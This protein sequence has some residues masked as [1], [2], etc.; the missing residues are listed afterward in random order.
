MILQKKTL[1][2]VDT[3]ATNTNKNLKQGSYGKIM[4]HKHSKLTQLMHFDEIFAAVWFQYVET[5]P[6]Q[7]DTSDDIDLGF[8]DDMLTKVRSSYELCV[9]VTLLV[10]LGNAA[11]LHVFC[12]VRRFLDPL[13]P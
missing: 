9:L 4:I 8:C 1:K 6:N 3:N 13:H 10:T 11:F 12:V 7:M 2:P 5:L